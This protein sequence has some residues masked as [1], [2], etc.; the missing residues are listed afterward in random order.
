MQPRVARVADLFSP[1]A[2][3]TLR[4][5]SRRRV[6]R[7]H[8]VLCGAGGAAIYGAGEF[9]VADPGDRW[10]PESEGVMQGRVLGFGCARLGLVCGLAVAGLSVGSAS[11]SADV[12]S[13][14]PPPVT[15]H[16]DGANGSFQPTG[17]SA[18]PGLPVSV[19]ATGLANF[20]AGDGCPDSACGTNPDGVSPSGGT[21]G[22]AGSDF[23][24]PGLPAFSL[25]GEVAG[26]SPFEV[27]SSDVI[28]GDGPISL[29][30]NDNYFG[31]NSGG[32]T[33]TLTTLDKSPPVIAQPA[34]VTVDATGPNGATVSYAL[35]DVT[36]LGYTGVTPTCSPASGT[37]FPI[38][39]TTVTCNASDPSGN[40]ATPVTFVVHVLSPAQQLA[41]LGNAAQA[42]GSSF[43]TQIQAALASVNA[44]N[45]T[46]AANQLQA[47]EHH[48]Q[49]Q[50]G[51]QLTASQASDL[52]NAAQTIIA[53]LGR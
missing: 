18:R 9:D 46:A 35:P 16:V 37:Q 24:G 48:V 51:K 8:R 14:L 19:S 52:L 11:A 50:T 4:C 41:N 23:L 22:L 7:P 28:S 5:G 45:P 43:G 47:F 13:T 10:S 26:G 6:T 39:D 44:A 29:G 38:G 2:C 15:V 53:A 36:D 31:D 25:V 40:V 17:V 21:F 20:G 12:V 27:G 3:A 49:A 32:Y 30:Y 34:D 1:A 33:V 42:A